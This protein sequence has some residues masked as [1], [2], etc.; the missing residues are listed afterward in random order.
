MTDYVPGCKTCRALISETAFHGLAKEPIPL[1][2]H[3]KIKQREHEVVSKLKSE[4][5][6]WWWHC[7]YQ[8]LTDRIEFQDW[9]AKTF[10]A[11][12]LAIFLEMDWEEDTIPSKSTY[13]RNIWLAARLMDV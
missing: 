4:I 10:T 7:E 2:A 6:D 11:K 13:L 12:Q 8:G 3:L 1:Q 5:N 9:L